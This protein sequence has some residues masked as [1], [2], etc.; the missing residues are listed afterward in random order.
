MPIL[1]PT[2]GQRS[3]D[4]CISNFQRRAFK[5]CWFE[6]ADF[7]MSPSDIELK[8]NILLSN[9]KFELCFHQA[10]LEHIE[11]MTWSPACQSHSAATT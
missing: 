7:Q 3:A 1:H 2:T 6:S 8:L 5:M 11:I 10:E 4:S 9:L